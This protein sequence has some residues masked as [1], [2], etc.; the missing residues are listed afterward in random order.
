MSYRYIIALLLFLI[1]NSSIISASINKT[2]SLKKVS[3][4]LAPQFK[5]ELSDTT[6]VNSLIAT[7]NY[8][9]EEQPDSATEYYKQSI[10]LIEIIR[11]NNMGVKD[12][13][14]DVKIDYKLSQIYLQYGL[15]QYYLGEFIKAK[16]QYQKTISLLQKHIDKKIKFATK[17]NFLALKAKALAQIGNCNWSLSEYD[18]AFKNYSKALE[19][20]IKIDNKQQQAAILGN[21]GVIM[22]TQGRYAEALTY[23]FQSLKIEEEI[24][25]EKGQAVTLGN[26]GII[27]YN[28]KEYEKALDYY[29]KSLA[30]KEKINETN[31]ISTILGNIGIVYHDQN[32]FD[33]ALEYYQKGLAVDR[34]Y[35]NKYGI[36]RH[37]GNIGLA[38][39][40][41]K[42]FKK[43]LDYYFEALKIDEELNN[44]IGIAYQ[45][46][47]I[48]NLYMLLNE[49]KKAEK[50][51]AES[52]QLSKEIGSLEVLE[53]STGK[54]SE[55]YEKNNKKELAFDFYKLFIQYKDSLLKEENTK[56]SIE[57][58]M[59]YLYEKKSVADSLAYEKE[60]AL[61]KAEKAKQKAEI[62]M[63]KNQQYA[64]FGG[65]FLIILFSGFMYNRFRVTNKQKQIIESQKVIVEQKNIEIVDS[66]KYAKRIQNAILPADELLKQQLKDFFVLYHPK[67]IVSGDFYWLE[68][69]E[70]HILFA[71]ADCTGHGVPGA[72][73][74]VVCANSLSKAL[75]EVKEAIPAK[76]LD[77][78]KQLVV[79]HFEK[80]GED[81]KDGMDIALCSL[82]LFES[83]ATLQYAGANNP[84]YIVRENREGIAELTEIKPN[85]QPI[86]KYFRQ[87]LFTNH[88]IELQKGDTIYVFTDG[89]A[90]QFGGPKGKKMMYKPFKDLLLNIQDKSMDEQ[91]EI[92]EQHFNDWKGSLEQVDDVCIIGVRI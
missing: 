84:L 69:Y 59:Q 77:K 92:L 6:F 5:G 24:N 68:K 74:S 38:Y 32:N 75:L 36:S 40:D 52:Y 82:K 89:Y 51:L 85:K 33:K 41:K 62:K 54:L 61:S 26:I 19:I 56:A 80:S 88:E 44:K 37:L 12:Q 31:S 28:Q 91:K 90:D 46:S 9:S 57:K 64:L 22:D 50:Y 65:L 42:D 13:G 76:I 53:S 49:H 4:L 39:E 34:K 20:N 72:M 43:A 10:N 30:L 35:N 48:G 83:Y 67:D 58:E 14:I 17:N 45:K 66:I 87:E 86:G 71:A 25:N 1:A 16:N 18:N 11:L 47:Y 81:V 29:E 55:L 73:V 60:K 15:T 21:M 27:Y 2:D 79:E 23:Y 3:K 7:G 78:T 70:N 63:I 8:Y